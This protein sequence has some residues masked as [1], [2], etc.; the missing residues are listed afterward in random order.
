MRLQDNPYLPGDLPGLARQLDSLYRQIATQLNQLTEGRITAVTNAATAP[1]VSGEWMQGDFI[2][3]SEPSESG[4][5]ATVTIGWV[6][7]ESGEPGT[8][9]PCQ[10]LTGN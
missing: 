4:S 8:W 1:P 2:R 5:P 3:N 6:C 10:F 9:V 7:I